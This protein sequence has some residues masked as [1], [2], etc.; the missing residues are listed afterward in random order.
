MAMLLL[1]GAKPLAGLMALERE[2]L[3][4]DQ[5]G[6]RDKNLASLRESASP[7]RVSHSHTTSADHPAAF[8]ATSVSASRARLRPILRCQ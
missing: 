4:V 3:G 8:S 6:G 5:A 7:S 1:I 2:A